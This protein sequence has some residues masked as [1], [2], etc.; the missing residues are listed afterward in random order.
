MKGDKGNSFTYPK[1][2]KV[3]GNKISEKI[4]IRNEIEKFWINISGRPIGNMRYSG[5]MELQMERRDLEI[6]LEPP[7][8]EEI[9]AV[10]K[11]L[12][13]EKGWG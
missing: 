10:V 2:L 8:L 12:K 4:Q 5:G 9:E 3:P 13:N 1:Y 6:S 7:S 11:K